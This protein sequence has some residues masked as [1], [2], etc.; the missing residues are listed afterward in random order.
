MT[1]LSNR[2]F[3][4]T[5]AL[6]NGVLYRTQDETIKEVVEPGFF[7]KKVLDLGTIVLID[8]ADGATMAVVRSVTEAG[9]PILEL[10][11]AASMRRSAQDKLET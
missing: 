11:R 2:L 5:W 7:P 4:G 9:T 1:Y 6:S 8:A 3:S 10:F